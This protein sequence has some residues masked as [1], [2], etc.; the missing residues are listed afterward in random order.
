MNSGSAIIE[1]MLDDSSYEV[2]RAH[3]AHPRVTTLDDGRMR[4][5]N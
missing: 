1:Q 5:M 3:H 2:W 4:A